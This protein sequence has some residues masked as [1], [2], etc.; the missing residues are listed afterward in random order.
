M[1]D[2]KGYLSFQCHD[3]TQ[4]GYYITNGK[5]VHIKWGKSSD[6]S[7]TKYY[8]DDLTQVEF[9]PGKTFIAVVQND[10]SVNIDGVE[11]TSQVK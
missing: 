7:P 9:N 2:A 11:Y 5:A 6:Y 1:R 3:D 8:Y 10:R 4:D